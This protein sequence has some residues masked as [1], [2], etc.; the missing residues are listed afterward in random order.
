MNYKTTSKDQNDNSLKKPAS[1]PFAN[2]FRKNEVISKNKLIRPF[3]AKT[4]STA[5]TPDCGPQKQ[6]TRIQ[7]DC[8]RQ[9]IQGLVYASLTPLR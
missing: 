2:P 9:Q 5:N 6:Y 4:V 1:R 3:L 8:E 7:L